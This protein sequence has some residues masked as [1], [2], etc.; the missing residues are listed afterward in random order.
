MARKKRVIYPGTFDPI[1]LG[2]IDIVKRSLAI[3][4]EVIVAVAK[5]PSKNTLF[6]F[7]ERLQI[8]KKALS[9]LSSVK[10]VGFDGLVVDFA[11]KCEAS[12]IVRGLRILSDFEYEFQ[13]AL[14]NRKISSKVETIFLMAHH[15]YS[16]ISSSLIK[17][18]VRLGAN[19]KDF[20][21]SVSL[22]ALQRKFK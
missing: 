12:C 2:H 6:S 11:L 10:V 14:T 3:F 17:E 21:P 1:T 13:M 5:S 8:A 18:A 22:K 9:K 19:L 15:K 7:S 4:D 16:Y 20:L